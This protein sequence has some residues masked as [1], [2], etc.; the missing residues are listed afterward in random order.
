MLQSRAELLQNEYK[1]V[2]ENHPGTMGRQGKYD[3]TDFLS[4]MFSKNHESGTLGLN[5]HDSSEVLHKSQSMQM[6]PET[7][8]KSIASKVLLR[9]NETTSQES[10]RGHARKLTLKEK[11]SILE[12]RKLNKNA[13]TLGRNYNSQQSN[14]SLEARPSKVEVTKS[15]AGA[16]LKQASMNMFGNEIGDD[17][18]VLND[19]D[20]RKLA[21]LQLINASARYELLSANQQLID[22]HL[23]RV[24]KAMFNKKEQ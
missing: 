9:R 8:Q 5:R 24:M 21:R 15:L 23:N 4:Q 14:A 17:E 3:D 1:K 6:I 16:E 13:E 22:F 18:D 7:S 11:Q 10:D 2:I 20:V 19:D 12:N